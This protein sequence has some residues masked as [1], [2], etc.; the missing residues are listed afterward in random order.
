MKGSAAVV[1]IGE[2][3]IDFTTDRTQP[4]GYPVMAAH[5]GGAP[6]NYL[7]ALA[8]YGVDTA[9]LGTVGDDAFGR[10]LV[11]TVRQSGIAVSGINTR[12]DAFT[13]MAFVTRDGSGDRAFSF[14]RKP[15]ADTLFEATP[16]ACAAVEAAKV[17]HFGTVGMTTEPSRSAHRALVERARNAGV[18]ISFDPNLREPLWES[19]DDAKAQMLWGISRAD[20][21]KISDN[22]VSFLYGLGPEAGAAEILAKSGVKLVYVTCGKD[23]CYFATRAVKGFVPSLSGLS[24]IDTTGAGDIFGGSA[25]CALLKTGRQPED[26]TAAEL[27]GIVRFASAAAG[28]STTKLGGI[29]SVPAMEEIDAVLRTFAKTI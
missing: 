2:L 18:M 26:L 20:V 1:A 24:V 5:P 16:E 27:E 10:L 15:G 4:D 28:L 12:A 19:L 3:L 23:G 17:L 9:M 11:E 13:T 14:A 6:A 29:S 8:K 7:A 21:L 22:E 25:M